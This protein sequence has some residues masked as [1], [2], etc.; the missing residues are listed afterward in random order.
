[1]KKCILLAAALFTFG[2]TAS[3][4]LAP[5]VKY[6]L[7][8]SDQAPAFVFPV[9]LTHLNSKVDQTAL[10]ATVTAGV[11]AA[12][13]GKVIAGQ[14]LFDLVGN[15]SWELAETI[16]MEVK[17]STWTMAGPGERI[18]EELS[19]I[20]ESILNKLAEL[21]LIPKGYR[22]KYIVA[23]HSHGQAQSIAGKDM[24]TI[25]T[26]G[27]IYDIETKGILAYINSVDRIPNDDKSPLVTI[28]GVYKK[29][30]SALIGQ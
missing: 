1:M 30:I 11:T 15:L 23:V 6:P 17:Q 2:C 7:P 22:F 24:L 16:D 21:N 26:W 14:P 8:I 25:N 3:V 4:T 19:K 12:F 28:P 5:G 20:T 27:G 9:N 10:M 13:K 18:A 29:V